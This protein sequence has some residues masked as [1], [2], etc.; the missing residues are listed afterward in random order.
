MARFHQI[1]GE[2]VA[3]TAEQEA[4]WD[5]EKAAWDAAAGDRAWSDLRV[6]RDQLLGASDWWAVSDRTLSDAE[7]AYRKS[8]RDLPANTADPSDV[9]WPTEP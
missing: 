5:S 9:T 6:K 1:D 4:A 7:T 2:L 3:F 8:L